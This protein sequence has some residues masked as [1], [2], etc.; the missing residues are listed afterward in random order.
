M[1]QMS[2]INIQ[3]PCIA[4][5]RGRDPENPSDRTSGNPNL[6]QRL[7][8]NTEGITYAITT[9]SK[10]NW[11]LELDKGEEEMCDGIERVGQISND[12]SQYGTVVSEEGINPTVAAGT[13]GYTNNCIQNKYKIRKLTPREC[14]RLMDYADSDFNK[15]SQVNSNTQLYKQAGNGI[16]RNCLVAIFGQMFEGKENVYKNVIKPGLR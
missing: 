8:L 11:L 13:H 14:W 7:E 9:V 2:D 5:S 1:R 10:D 12:G 16:A 3:L 4:A 6:E 15:A